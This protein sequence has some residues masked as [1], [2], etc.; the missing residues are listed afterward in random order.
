MN[1]NACSSFYYSGGSGISQPNQS[2]GELKPRSYFYFL[3]QPI[4]I[5]YLLFQGFPIN[6]MLESAMLIL[7]DFNGPSILVSKFCKSVFKV[8]NFGLYGYL[9]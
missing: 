9:Y 7:Q 5:F 4:N 3:K 2:Y 1:L 6:R 8:F